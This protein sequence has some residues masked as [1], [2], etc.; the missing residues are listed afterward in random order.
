[1]NA[2]TEYAATLAKFV[3]AQELAKHFVLK[4]GGRGRDTAHCNE[5]VALAAKAY[6]KDTAGFEKF[7]LNFGGYTPGQFLMAA[8]GRPFKARK[9]GKKDGTQATADEIAN[10]ALSD[11][12][13]YMGV[14]R[15]DV[16]YNKSD[17][18]LVADMVAPA[19]VAKKQH[20]KTSNS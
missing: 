4:C 10:Q 3:K 8:T 14:Q 12:A 20:K 2:H 1:M 16:R 13:S 18:G 9:S 11:L 6:D 17:L 5:V 15:P 19:T 7:C